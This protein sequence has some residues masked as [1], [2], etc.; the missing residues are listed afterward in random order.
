MAGASPHL[1][2]DP[3]R[4]T[5]VRAEREKQVAS[6]AIHDKVLLAS[7]RSPG[8]PSAGSSPRRRSS[9]GGGDDDLPAVFSRLTDPRKCVCC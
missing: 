4:L 5:L 6:Q 1:T 8:S 2:T 3:R 9:T 7:L